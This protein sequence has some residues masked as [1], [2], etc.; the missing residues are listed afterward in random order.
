MPVPLLIHFNI[1]EKSAFRFCLS[2]ARLLLRHSFSSI[3][4]ILVVEQGVA[5][6]YKLIKNQG[7][8][9]INRQTIPSAHKT[10]RNYRS[11]KFANTIHEK[12][13]ANAKTTIKRQHT[14]TERQAKKL[15]AVKIEDGHG[16]CSSPLPLPHTQPISTFGFSFS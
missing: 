15:P 6:A 12:H 1:Q 4:F 16:C 2:Y 8:G 14:S 3:C 11:I 9:C 13:A 10:D 5:I 7:K